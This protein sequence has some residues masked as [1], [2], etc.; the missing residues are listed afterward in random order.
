MKLT[1]ERLKQII[2]EELH[3]MMGMGDN[4]SKLLDSDDESMIMQGIDL[5]LT[6][7]M[8]IVV[9]NPSRNILSYVQ[10]STDSDLLTLMA[11]PETHKRI[12]FRIAQNQNTPIKVIRDIATNHAYN[13]RAANLA[14]KSLNI[15]CAQY[16]DDEIC[17]DLDGDMEY[18]N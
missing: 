16:S 13:V 8:P 15:Y 2:K 17:G 9:R 10:N 4:L 14:T 18:R 3:E 5:A 1:T 6:L 11:Q 12:L 7:G